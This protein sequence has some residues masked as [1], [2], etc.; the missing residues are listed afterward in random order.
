[1]R[2]IVASADMGVDSTGRLRLLRYIERQELLRYLLYWDKV[3]WAV[4]KGPNTSVTT[5]R[6]L[7]IDAG[8][9]G[10]VRA[11]DVNV[12]MPYSEGELASLVAQ[13]LVLLH[14]APVPR[15]RLTP[16]CEGQDEVFGF[17]GNELNQAVLLAQV[18]LERTLNNQTMIG[19][20]WL[21]GHSGPFGLEESQY[22]EAGFPVVHLHH[23][24]PAPHPD[25]PLMTLLE[26]RTK[27]RRELLAFRV[28]FETLE[29]RLVNADNPR[30]EGCRIAEELEESVLRI[31]D[32]MDHSRVRWV[33]ET[34]HS[35]T[36]YLFAP[37]S[38]TPALLTGLIG[39]EFAGLTGLLVVAGAAALRA[40][41]EVSTNRIPRDCSFPT[42]LRPYQYLYRVRRELDS[43]P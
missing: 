1:M 20:C 17:R 25:T 42:R 40:V 10:E 36:R 43:V 31:V 30:T 13:G 34:L 6:D 22:T 4:P 11:R 32:L 15:E 12:C 3:S 28:L 16:D 5:T 29:E 19:D 23:L 27:Y 24:L 35:F 39:Y 26:F 7:Q 2:G 8:M 9:F 14:E 18:A 41:V 21:L 37:I 38:Q 33:L